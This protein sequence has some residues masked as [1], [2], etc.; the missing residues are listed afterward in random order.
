[1][2]ERISYIFRIFLF[3]VVSFIIQKPLFMLY[4]KDAAVVS[5][6]Y[7]SDCID[8][9]IHGL[10]LDVTT[11][12][13]LII[14]PF[15]LVVISFFY[16]INI[17]RFAAPYYIG[18]ASVISLIFIADTVIYTF[19]GFKLNSTALLYT[20]HPSA[21]AASVSGVFII[22]GICAVILTAALYIY[23]LCVLTPE[24]LTQFR[25]NKAWVSV[26]LPIGLL[27]FLFIRGGT[28]ESTSNISKAYY[29]NRQ[30]LNHSAINP[31]FNLFYSLSK[32]KYFS[33]EFHVFNEAEK[34]ELTNGIFT[35]E[36]IDN[37]KVLNIERP[38]ILLIIWEGC[39]GYFVEST[40][41]DKNITPCLNTIAR[42]SI[43]FTNCYA[44]SFRTDR[45]IVCIL[46]GWL[47]FPTASI[48]KT[49]E[50]SR[51]LPSL[52]L[53]LGEKGYRT[54]FWYGG[55]IDFTNMKS[56][57]Y[58]SGYETLYSDNHFPQKYRDYS[59]WGVPDHIVFDSLATNI[60]NRKDNERWFTTVLTLSSHEPWEVPY[61]RIKDKRKNSFA[62]TD[63]CIGHFLESLKKT[64]A[65]ENLLVIILP[66][67]GIKKYNGQLGSDYQ[68]AHI[69]MI[70][71]GGAIAGRRIT[72]TLMSQSDMAATLLGQLHIR[73][74]SFLFSRD[75]FS[76]TYKYPSAFH[77][78]SNGMTFIDSSG[79][80]T[81]DNDIQKTILTKDTGR[82]CG[83]TTRVRHAKAILQTLYD[84]MSKR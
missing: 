73:H 63:H 32:S 5:E 77:T 54:D 38:N 49:T 51:T 68:I 84:D 18:V 11:A 36:S 66:D 53:S 17:K 74:E 3:F 43:V 46:N 42:E 75:I 50:K 82:Q 40:G 13:Y 55:N 78:F 12:T 20:D 10:Q 37:E 56:Y 60:R 41:G 61:S 21:I 33:K 48:M 19:W 29:S 35:T 80:S 64:E 71:T 34:N 24:H 65:W 6:T 52:A 23:G 15:V 79:I 2:K 58:E 57:L 4:N 28:G 70:W 30:F 67:H 62:Y 26:I 31:V 47:G 16:N 76:R 39:P 14:Y 7:F 27:M 69:P 81:F 9:V 25:H 59:K 44:G 1:M 8:V 72:D 83:D 45:G 22:T